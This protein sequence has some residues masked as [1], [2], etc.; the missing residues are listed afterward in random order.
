[1]ENKFNKYDAVKVKRPFCDNFNGVITPN[2]IGFIEVATEDSFG[3]L[4]VIFKDRAFGNTFYVKKEELELVVKYDDYSAGHKISNNC[5]VKEKQ[6]YKLLK[7]Y[8]PKI[9]RPK[10]IIPYEYE[11]FVTV[12]EPMKTSGTT[13]IFPGDFG[14]IMEY[15]NEVY[16]SDVT[17]KGNFYDV[18]FNSPSRFP[19]HFMPGFDVK[20]CPHEV[21]IPFEEYKKI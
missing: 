11:F 14:K 2:E 6:L 4:G 21:L 19:Q 18:F 16:G 12:K 9:K 3:N 17:I 5:L 10:K 20:N 1:M 7:K 15:N 8:W 13:V